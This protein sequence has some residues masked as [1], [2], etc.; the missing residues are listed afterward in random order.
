MKKV[1]VFLGCTILGEI[2]LVG[3]DLARYYASL[4]YTEGTKATM[5]NRLVNEQR[6]NPCV[7]T[8]DPDDPA[9]KLPECAEAVRAIGGAADE[10]RKRR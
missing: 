2:S 4:H 1:L 5:R 8:D 7:I 10:R 9:R 6:S 3:I